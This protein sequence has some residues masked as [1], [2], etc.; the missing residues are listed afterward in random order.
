MFNSIDKVERPSL[1]PALTLAIIGDTVY[2]LYFKNRLITQK[3]MLCGKIHTEAVRFVKASAQ[4]E[5]IKEIEPSLTEEEDAI[6][7]RGR[8]A[9]SQSVP[10]HA[11]L[12]DY[13]MATG[14][15]TLIGYLYLSE[16]YERIDELLNTTFN[17][18]DKEQE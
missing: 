8:N 13:H 16:R 17:I 10:R 2:D 4:A 15:E 9:K 5:A 12:G 7:K 6:Y 14:F 11:D 3:A 1:L 18:L